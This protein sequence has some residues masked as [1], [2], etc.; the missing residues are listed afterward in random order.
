MRGIL[1]KMSPGLGNCIVSGERT[2]KWVCKENIYV[3]AL[4][5]K[6]LFEKEPEDSRGYDLLLTLYQVPVPEKPEWTVLYYQY[7]ENYIRRLNY[8]ERFNRACEVCEHV[9]KLNPDEEKIGVMYQEAIAGR[10]PIRKKSV[11]P[12]GGAINFSLEAIANDMNRKRRGTYFCDKEIFQQIYL[13]GENRMHFG[14]ITISNPNPIVREGALSGVYSILKTALMSG[15]VAARYSSEIIVLLLAAK[16]YRTAK[17]AMTRIR[18]IFYGA[19]P[20]G[21]YGFHAKYREINCKE[22][23]NL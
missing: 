19:Y 1:N 23:C 4:E 13:A 10:S 21:Q 22:T 16:N 11:I 15:D 8:E 5:A 14:I 17:E 2:Y 3:D 18:D 7:M 12:Y 20:S 6:K 9:L